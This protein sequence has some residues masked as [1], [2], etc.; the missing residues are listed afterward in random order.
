MKRL[1][2]FF[3]ALFT[4][5]PALAQLDL[6]TRVW[7]P[8][9][10]PAVGGYPDAFEPLGFQTPGGAVLPYRLL[11][12][13]ATAEP[14]PLIIM[15]HGSG[16][17]MG[18]DNRVH[19]EGPFMSQWGAPGVLAAFP[20]YVAAPQVAVRSVYYMPSSDGMPASVPGPALADLLALVEHL[21][22]TLPVD[23]RRVY[24]IG[25]SMG[26]S[27]ALQALMARPDLFAAGVTF[28]AIGP[29]RAYAPL[30]AQT[31]VLLVHGDKDPDNRI[32]PDLA[33]AEA[34]A[35]AGGK[36]RMIVYQG[37]D[38]RVPTDMIAGSDWR[39]WLF[40]QAKPETPPAELAGR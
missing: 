31:P 8:A 33:W 27:A 25:F 34:L 40:S 29:D 36:P 24:V 1:I 2:A 9:T 32:E 39:A 14:P 26:G 35:A 38:H 17:A 37:M 16:M 23:R 22:A 11:T 13:P 19:I 21:T 3:T 6:E 4:A 18:T 12:P 10:Q 15:L 28:A 20:A 7:T 5:H 30:A